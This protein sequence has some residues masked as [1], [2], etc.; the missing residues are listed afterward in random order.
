M[1][2]HPRKDYRLLLGKTWWIQ[3]PGADEQLQKKVIISKFKLQQ[4]MNF[5]FVPLGWKPNPVFFWARR[6]DGSSWS[7][8]LLKQKN[9]NSLP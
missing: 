1:G 9:T 3:I 6:F 4:M 7:V 5:D 8:S 2:Q